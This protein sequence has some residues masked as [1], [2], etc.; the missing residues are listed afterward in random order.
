MLGGWGQPL[1]PCP[2]SPPWLA[3]ASPGSGAAGSSP[4]PKSCLPCL[5][6]TGG[7]PSAP[8]KVPGLGEA[9]AGG[10]RAG[11]ARSSLLWPVGTSA[12]SSAALAPPWHKQSPS[13]PGPEQGSLQ[14]PSEHQFSAP[15]AQRAPF[16]CGQWCACLCE[17]LEAWLRGLGVA[18]PSCQFTPNPGAGRGL[19]TPQV[20]PAPGAPLPSQKQ[21]TPSG[22]HAPFSRGFAWDQ[23]V[24]LCSLVS[25]QCLHPF[26]YRLLLH[27]Q[28]GALPHSPA[29]VPLALVPVPR[30]SCWHVIELTS[31]AP[32]AQCHRCLCVSVPPLAAAP[33]D[34]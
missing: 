32:V 11:G 34:A 3:A 22:P 29:L 14:F 12:L 33:M 8:H 4:R 31:S 15:I 27:S 1:G 6:A 30:L 13:Q 17:C 28:A 21:G 24:S 9:G 16:L 7:C 18:P 10:T 23:R 26:F 25:V 20:N 5:A 19:M 2:G